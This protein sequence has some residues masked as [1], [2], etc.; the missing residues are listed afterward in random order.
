[1]ERSHLAWYLVRMVSRPEK[2]AKMHAFY[3]HS[4]CEWTVRINLPTISW[5]WGRRGVTKQN[6]V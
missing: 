6:T 3:F 4:P 1:M 5:R 2:T